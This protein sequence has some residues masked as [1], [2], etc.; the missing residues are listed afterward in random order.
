MSEALTKLRFHMTHAMAMKMSFSFPVPCN[1]ISKGFPT[2][3][4]EESKWNE[5]Q[6]VYKHIND[7]IRVQI[8]FKDGARFRIIVGMKQQIEYLARQVRLKH[9][10]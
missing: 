3:P 10:W 5:L 2:K 6:R 8:L 9:L 4:T 7:F 1:P